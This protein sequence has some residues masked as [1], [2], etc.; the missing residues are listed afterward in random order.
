MMDLF[1]YGTLMCADIMRTVSGCPELVG[2][3]GLLRDHCRLCVRGEH[4]PGLVPRPGASVQGIVYHAVPADARA[5]LDR[6][7][8]DMY[9]RTAVEVELTDA[10]ILRVQ[11]YLVRPEMTGLLEDRVW[12]LAD[13][14]RHGKA[15]FE[16]AYA[17]YSAIATTPGAS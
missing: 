8:G 9:V 14:L 12:R 3:A 1:A 7:E 5:R 4:Y 6:F 16:S 11:T 15:D 10:T 13:F 17:G 2:S